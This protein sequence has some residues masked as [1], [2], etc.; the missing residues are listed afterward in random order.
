MPGPAVAH[1][2]VIIC[3]MLLLL[4]ANCILLNA[5]A[6]TLYDLREIAV[7]A[8]RIE[9]TDIGKHSDKL[10][11]Q[12]LSIRH[13]DNLAA[14]LSSHTP[15]FAR[16]YGLGTLATL[17]IRGGSAAHTQILWN[18]IPLR[19]P[20]L[21]LVDLALIPG[22][23]IDEAA[24]H[25]GGHGAA[26]GSGAIGGLIS[27][28]NDKVSHSNRISL[29]SNTGSWDNQ[30]G[31]VR[32]DYGLKNLRFSSRF[33]VQNGV[34]NFKYKLTK[35]LP[36][37]YQ[38]HHRL[39]NHGFLQ[40]AGVYLSDRQYVT[41]RFWYQE[42]D[43]QIPPVSTQ[44]TSKAAQQ[45][46]NLRTSLQWNYQGDKFQWQFKT[47]FLDEIIDYQDTLILLYAH[48]RF[49]TWLAEAESSFRINPDIQFTG[50]IYSEVA[51]GE[52]ENYLEPLVRHQTAVF[53]SV[54][55]AIKKWN[56][57]LQAREEITQGAL[58]PL[59]LDASFEWSF[60]QGLVLK[61]S[62]SKNYRTPTLNDL[63]WRP[64][65]NPEL[66]PENGWTYEAGLH[67]AR[68][69]QSH[70]MI[71]S[72][73]GYTRKIENWIMWMPPIKGEKN[74][75]SPLNIAT[76]DSKGIESRIRSKIT[77]RNITIHLNAGLDL[78]WST[79]GTAL[80][81]FGIEAGEQ[82]FYVPVENIL[83]G[84]DIDIYNWSIFYDHHWFGNSS[85]INDMIAAANIGSG[86][87][88]YQIKK[89]RV[90]GMVYFQADNVWNVPYRIIERR[91]MPGRSFSIGIKFSFS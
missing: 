3:L 63:N 74:Y 89:G 24:I 68:S 23:F 37:K 6:D 53:S 22:S 4:W 82:L 91:P 81:E 31:Q 65:G 84:A 50:G 2:K 29:E 87:I 20:M 18:G 57:R 56:W 76:V 47:A 83:T 35:D 45:D 69:Y 58:S 16:S 5:Q 38:V 19:N 1:I 90:A 10:D 34:N 67:F 62:V 49:K 43:R 52:S 51:R 71:A 26:F 33:F 72:I 40:E 27:V 30:T 73:T 70:M 41:A 64:G 46:Q 25:Y 14:I 59:L 86:G 39:Q 55:L 44:N 79:F 75:W 36:D 15:L 9:L 85:G 60:L 66:L 80:E 48:N 32:I 17:G 54:R 78:T 7:T 77:G 42:T 13:H 21:G 61:S 8:Q 11:S 88:R 28:S 12:I